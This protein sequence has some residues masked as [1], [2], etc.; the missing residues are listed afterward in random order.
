MYGT[1]TAIVKQDEPITSGELELRVYGPF[2]IEISKETTDLCTGTG[3]A[4]PTSTGALVQGVVRQ[5][6]PSIAS[7]FVSQAGIEI[8]IRGNGKSL[9]CYYISVEVGRS[10]DVPPPAPPPWVQSPP[11][12]LFGATANLVERS[13]PGVGSSGGPRSSLPARPTPHCSPPEPSLLE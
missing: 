7:G 12:P 4:C 5:K 13:V 10:G 9:A 2:N 11:P 1:F 3:V 6:V 8:E